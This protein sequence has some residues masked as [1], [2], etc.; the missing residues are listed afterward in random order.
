MAMDQRLLERAKAAAADLEQVERRAAA[1]RDEYHACVRRLHLS[2][3][4]LREIA[5][6]LS[7]S[8]QRVQQIV[9]AAG[10]SWWMVWRTRRHAAQGECSW[11]DRP[12]HEVNR[13]IAGPDLYICDD[14]VAAA[15]AEAATP[16]SSEWGPLRLAEP[17]SP[18]EC[19]FC[20]KRPT[21]G[22]RVVEGPPNVCSECLVVCREILY[23]GA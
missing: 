6:A 17:D 10:G 9:Q 4:P 21:G 19:S 2:G 8:H 1:A 14:C 23:E 13:L 20:R 22:R 16:V 18:T 11:C 3:A 5:Q 12:A 15:G 7:L